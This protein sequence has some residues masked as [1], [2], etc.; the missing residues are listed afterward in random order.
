LI[1]SAA[2]YVAHVATGL[3]VWFCLPSWRRPP[4]ISVPSMR[5]A[6]RESVCYVERRLA[7]H[8]DIAILVDPDLDQLVERFH[9]L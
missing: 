5:G 8:A 6:S 3:G 9:G 1:G 7:G 2:G 4:D